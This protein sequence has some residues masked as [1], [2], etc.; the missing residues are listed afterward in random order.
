MM[1]DILALAPD[2]DKMTERSLQGASYR[3]VMNHPHRQ[4]LIDMQTQH[5]RRI[6]G[7]GTFEAIWP[8]PPAAERLE[9]P[10]V[11][12]LFLLGSEDLPD[13]FRIEELLLQK[14]PD[15]RSIR[16]EGADHMPT[17]THAEELARHMISFLEE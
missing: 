9:E 1:Q 5:M 16:I 11:P 7:W 14:V 15:I 17:L 12:T 6:F 3:V 2:P 10:R 8:Q 13:L 4:T